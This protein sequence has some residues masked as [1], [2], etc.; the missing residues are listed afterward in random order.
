[1]DLS[2]ERVAVVAERLGL[3]QL[4]CPVITVAGTNGKGSCVA[5]LEAIY[6][7]A[8]Y[9]VGA[10]TS[11]VLF[12]H[13]EYVRVQGVAC[14]DDIFCR[15]YE[16]I[17]AVLE[18]ITL[19]PFEFVTLAALLIF[20]E[21]A[22]DV[23][24]L[25]VGLGG[26][27]D[28]VNV[29]NADVAIVTSIGID[30]VEWLGHTCEAIGF[31]KAGIFRKNH[32]A[33]CGDFSPPVSLVNYA[34]QI[35]AEFFCQG[36]DFGFVQKD[37]KWD[38]FSLSRKLENLPLPTLS[39]Q[40]MASALMA[41][42]LLEKKLPATRDSIEHALKN[43]YLPGRIEVIPGDVFK[44]FDVSHN[45]AAASFLADYLSQH[46]INGKTRAVFSMLADKDIAGTIDVI[47]SYIDGWFIAPLPVVRGASLDSLKKCFSFSVNS[48]S[49]IQEAFANAIAI[50]QLGDRV[51]IFGS[52]HVVSAIKSCIEEL[53]HA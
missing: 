11:P 40:N 32:P 2:L 36:K 6:L 34:I 18:D 9:R 26:R 31:E 14:E 13:N 8:G 20:R 15:A 41:V 28:A 21:S 37:K 52:F 51:I 22:L 53:K 47:K 39:L 12:K 5:I 38:W 1:M 35:G 10:F 50:S 19:T 4:K 25:E 42:E 29:I 43:V 23:I 17:A 48:C 27:F 46:P 33:V 45:P 7:A 44:I 49:S 24:L 30:H 3:L 16:T